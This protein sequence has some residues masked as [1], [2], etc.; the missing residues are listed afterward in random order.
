ML[1]ADH[2]HVYEE[3]RRQKEEKLRAISHPN[4]NN[5]H[6]NQKE[7]FAAALRNNRWHAPVKKH[8]I[9]QNILDKTL[10]P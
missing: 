8:Q 6:Q 9:Y 3:Q 7:S 10:D 5:P 4:K 2:P 1:K